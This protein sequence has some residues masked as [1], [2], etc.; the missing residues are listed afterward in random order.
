MTC[1]SPSHLVVANHARSALSTQHVVE[2][3]L[4][5]FEGSLKAGSRVLHAQIILTV[6]SES[7]ERLD[8]QKPEVFLTG[9]FTGQARHGD[10]HEH[11]LSVGC[12]RTGRFLEQPTV[13]IMSQSAASWTLELLEGKNVADA[14]EFHAMHA[15]CKQ[16][17][18]ST[19][20][21]LTDV[22]YRSNAGPDSGLNAEY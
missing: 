22:A 14:A 2:E 17:S 7:R 1:C 9:G 16:G 19:R 3:W 15:P 18:C 4:Q 21:C 20:S 6:D 8:I 12:A 5:C 11:R 10:R 13:C